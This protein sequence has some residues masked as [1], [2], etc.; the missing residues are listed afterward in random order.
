MGELGELERLSKR[1]C[2]KIVRDGQ[3][4]LHKV[5]GGSGRKVSTTGWVQ[6]V[7]GGWFEVAIQLERPAAATHTNTDRDIKETEGGSQAVGNMAMRDLHLTKG[8]NNMGED[9]DTIA[10][11]EE[12]AW[13]LRG[14]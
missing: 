3:K 1:K 14:G 7:S 6:D 8:N 2:D 13:G 10:K 5:F 9:N 11:E 12:P 4:R